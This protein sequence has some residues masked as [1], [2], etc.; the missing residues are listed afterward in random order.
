MAG[1]RG[2]VSRVVRRVMYRGDGR[3]AHYINEPEPQNE[4]Q[5]SN[6]GPIL[7]QGCGA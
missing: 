2:A 6:E 1:E 7:R 3:E 5:R 4:R